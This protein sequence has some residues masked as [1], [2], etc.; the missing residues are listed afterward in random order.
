M[1]AIQAEWTQWI[2]EHPEVNTPSLSN[3]AR[4]YL[5]EMSQNRVLTE[6]MSWDHVMMKLA[7]TISFRSPDAQTRVGAVIVN[8]D[9]RILGMGYN[10]W[11]P[12]IDDTL[13]PNIRPLKYNFVI[14]AEL[15]AILN[16]EH[17][18]INGTLYCT[19]RPCPHCFHCIVTAG[20][21]ELVYT[22]KVVVGEQSKDVDW[23]TSCFL[24]RHKI[25][26]RAMV[27]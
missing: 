16:C 12:G 15:N 17:R 9:H 3:E 4:E 19:H 22:N 6:R 7:D 21:T 2:D 14:H 13:I 20:I 11:M 27:P 25:T 8:K 24:A 1:T 23:E 10:G 26:V 18:P 5:Y